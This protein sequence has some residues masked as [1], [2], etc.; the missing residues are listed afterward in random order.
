MNRRLMILFLLVP[1]LGAAAYGL[2][3]PDRPRAELERKYLERAC[4][5]R[6]VA[7]VRLHLCDS[8]PRNAPPVILLHGF[9]DSLQTW[10]EWAKSLQADHRVIR[11]DLPGAGLTGP[12]PTGDY[13][14]SRSVA[15]LEALMQT[16]GI[17]RASIVGNSIGGRIAWTFAAEKPALV[18]RLVLVSPDGFA[19]P[20]F[21]YGKA[22]EIPA[23]LKLMR[24]VLPKMLLRMNLT[25][26]YGN[27]AAL[28]DAVVTRYHDLI[29]APGVRGAMLDRMRQTVL[30]DPR[31]FLRRIQAPTL[32]LWGEKDGMIP[33]A[34]AADYVRELPHSELVKL[35]GLGHVPQEEAPDMS[36]K[37]V[38]AFLTR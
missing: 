12:D 22:P 8:G 15:V 26:A 33:V 5:Y 30:R 6:D 20:G 2:W 28:S 7:G 10:D 11:F 3:T 16:L 31:P 38:R 13:R 23:L 4:G 9:G 14:D 24:Y 19:S 36:L 25:A 18:D 17:A 1:A 37:P 21:E 35:P 32:L 27:P 34:N 29:L